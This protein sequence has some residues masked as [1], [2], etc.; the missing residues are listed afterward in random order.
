MERQG[1]VVFLDMHWEISN[2]KVNPKHLQISKGYFSPTPSL[3]R[4]LLY[5][6]V[7]P[8]EFSGFKG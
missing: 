8:T 1:E 2:E 7:G 4:Q 3:K 5:S 6:R